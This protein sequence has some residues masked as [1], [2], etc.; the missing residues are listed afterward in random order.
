MELFHRP[1]VNQV[2]PAEGMLLS[3][4]PYETPDPELIQQQADAI[5]ADAENLTV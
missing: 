4:N 5:A 1:V 2:I 3:W